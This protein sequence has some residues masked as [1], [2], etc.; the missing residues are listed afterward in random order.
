MR[1]QKIYLFYRFD[2]DAG[3]RLKDVFIDKKYSTVLWKPTLLKIIPAGLKWIPFSIWW[4]M[5]NLYMFSN[6]DYG[7]YLIYDEE[8]LIHRSVIMPRYF[9]FPFMGKK[10]LQIGDTWTMPEYRGEGLAPF[11]VQGVVKSLKKSKRKFWYV[12][13]KDNN[14]SIRSIKKAGFVKYG[15]GVRKER[16]NLKVIGQYKMTSFFRE[17]RLNVKKNI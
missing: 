9:R 16:M 11:A 14:P 8:I 15:T 1:D 13:E 7:L 3:H 6:K 17:V 5:N 12:V 4:V 10:D 2:F